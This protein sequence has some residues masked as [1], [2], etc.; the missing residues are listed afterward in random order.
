MIEG[1]IKGLMQTSCNSL[2][3]IALSCI[4][5]NGTMRVMTHPAVFV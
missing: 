3:Y 4:E 5:L 1:K 2:I